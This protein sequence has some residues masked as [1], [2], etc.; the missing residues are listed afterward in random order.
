M[1]LYLVIPLILNLLAHGFRH[2]SYRIRNTIEGNDMEKRKHKYNSIYLFF[3]VYIPSLFVSG[4]IY[5]LYLEAIETQTVLRH[6]V[7]LKALDKSSSLE[8]G[9]PKD[10]SNLARLKSLNEKE[11][12]DIASSVDS[13]LKRH[14]LEYYPDSWNKPGKILLESYLF[15]RKVV[16]FGDGSEAVVSRWL[17]RPEGVEPKYGPR[18]SSDLFFISTFLVL[19]PIVFWVVIAVIHLAT[20]TISGNK[21]QSGDI[22]TNL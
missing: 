17:N 5:T 20:K 10:I 22:K 19:P 6:K 7:I 9:I 21:N 11:K 15:G 16:T 13:E 1:T 3:V 14:S 18:F 8:N 12:E 2:F 4:L